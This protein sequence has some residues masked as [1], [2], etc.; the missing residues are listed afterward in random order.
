M[1]RRALWRR[2]M[3]TCWPTNSN[4]T[5]IEKAVAYAAAFFCAQKNIGS[6]FNWVEYPA[7][8][9]PEVLFGLVENYIGVLVQ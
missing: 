3:T 6:V 4:S 9:V 1:C 2:Q 7:F 5:R 8:V